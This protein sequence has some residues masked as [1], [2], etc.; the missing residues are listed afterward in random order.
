MNFSTISFGNWR[1]AE[2]FSWFEC[3]AD[4]EK[5]IFGRSL[6]KMVNNHHWRDI[7]RDIYQLPRDLLS[8]KKPE[9]QNAQISQLSRILEKISFLPVFP[10]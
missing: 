10:V 8:L 5:Y 1:K 6:L 3:S 2:F 4:C 7:K 9:F